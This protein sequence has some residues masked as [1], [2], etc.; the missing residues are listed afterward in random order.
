MSGIPAPIYTPGFAFI[1]AANQCDELANKLS[2]QA[3]N[4]YKLEDQVTAAWRGE[5]GSSLVR[6]L[7]DKSSS[8]TSAAGILRGAASD[9]RAR[10]AKASEHH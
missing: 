3:G 10:A 7:V 2:D 5:A 8:L 1:M 9:L 6:A 4:V